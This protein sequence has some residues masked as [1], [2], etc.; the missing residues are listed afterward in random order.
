MLPIQIYSTVIFT[1]TLYKNKTM[2]IY[3]KKK[4]RTLKSFV[5]ERPDACYPKTEYFEGR[6]DMHSCCFRTKTKT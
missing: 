2:L 3:G 1:F 5:F 6:G 4:K